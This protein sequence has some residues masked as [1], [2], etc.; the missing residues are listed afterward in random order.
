[1]QTKSHLNGKTINLTGDNTVIK[2]TNFNVD[3][4]GNMTC[5]NAKVTGGKI[6]LEAGTS[7]N[8]NFTI[9]DN[10]YITGNYFNM[11]EE[12]L[13]GNFIQ[14]FADTDDPA[15]ISVNSNMS[16]TR[17]L[18]TKIETPAI[19]S[20]PIYNENNVTGSANMYITSGGNVRR[21]TGSSKRWKKDIT[22]EIEE[23]LN[24]EALYK[25]PI[26]QYKYKDEFISKDDVRRGKNILG[27]IAE[28]VAEI[29][30]PAVQYDEN[31]QIEMW[32]KEVMIPAMLKLI[33]E[34]HKEQ[35]KQQEEIEELKQEIIKLKGE[36]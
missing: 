21:T 28:D 36:Q 3:K 10:L 31:G 14:M 2:S 34:Q 9:G 1:M 7:A 16:Q 8:P 13:G 15:E 5:S 25:I 17:I 11:G 18:G 6:T 30:E 19:Q 35:I 27:F 26:K 29:Y 20:L 33:Q 12:Y 22:E 32:N 24:P 23:R 4:N